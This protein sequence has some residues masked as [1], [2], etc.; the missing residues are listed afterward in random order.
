MRGRFHAAV[1]RRF[2]NLDIPPEV[3]TMPWVVHVTAWPPGEDAILEYLAR[4]VFRVAITDRR[5]L[6]VD[7]DSVTF[8]YKDRKS[9][10]MKTCRVSG[11]EF[12]RRF[13]QHV[14]PKGFHK[15]RYAGLWHPTKRDQLQRLQQVLL[16]DRRET[17]PA[18][19]IAAMTEAVPTADG[20]TSPSTP[21]PCPHCRQGHFVFFR[22][23]S[24]I[25]PRAP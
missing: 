7:D 16:L 8:Q 3:W 18:E 25:R 2:P 15:V 13:L 4:Y 21:R 10:H 20:G 14:L 24:P 23:V 22:R 12:L 9:G 6:A 17:L 11:H 5:I 1:T 19:D